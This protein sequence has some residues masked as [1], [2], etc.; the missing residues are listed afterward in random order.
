MIEIGLLDNAKVSV[1]TMA[2]GAVTD[3]LL[4][5]HFL[6]EMNAT[7]CRKNNPRGK[8]LKLLAK[9]FNFCLKYDELNQR[10]IPF[11]KIFTILQKQLAR[12]KL[13]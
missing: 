9:Y 8:I 13:F 11:T 6:N 10:S 2:K 4:K 5:K 12:C 3:Q 7:D 1:H